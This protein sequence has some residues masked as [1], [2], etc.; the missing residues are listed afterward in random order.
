M[1]ILF[2]FRGNHIATSIDDRLYSVRGN[3][4]GYYNESA[5][6]FTDLQ[7]KYLGQI[8]FSNRLL[9]SDII[10]SKGLILGHVMSTKALDQL[11]T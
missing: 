5:K 2:N 10:D 1:Q 7:G 4:I 11:V 3:H 6:I 9:Q 8:P